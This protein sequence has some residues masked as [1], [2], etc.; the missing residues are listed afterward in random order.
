M[1]LDYGDYHFREA[2]VRFRQL[3]AEEAKLVSLAAKL[4]RKPTL[5]AARLSSR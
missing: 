1:P 3:R 2:L 4:P 5:P